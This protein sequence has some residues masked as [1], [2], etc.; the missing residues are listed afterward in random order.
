MEETTLEELDRLID[1]NLFRPGKD[2]FDYH[3]PTWGFPREA[4]L[5]LA[6]T[7]FFLPR[8]VRGHLAR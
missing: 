6:M 1:I 2:L 5:A 7:R 8:A 4:A 3:F